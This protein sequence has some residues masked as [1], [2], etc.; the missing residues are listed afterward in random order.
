[1]ESYIRIL[2]PAIVLGFFIAKFCAGKKSG[3]QGRFKSLI[4]K[5]G[6]YKIH[7][8]HWFFSIIIL[9]ALIAADF[10]HPL[11]YG[12]LIGI[13]LQGFTYKNFYKIIY[14]N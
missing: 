6:Q 10:Y 8:H 4:F 13:V 5:V 9:F 2:V 3:E 14:R 1:M 11:I 12:I 7:I